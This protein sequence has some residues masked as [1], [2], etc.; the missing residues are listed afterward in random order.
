M[1][2]EQQWCNTCL[3]VP[4][5]AFGSFRRDSALLADT[6]STKGPS[7]VCHSSRDLNT[8]WRIAAGTSSA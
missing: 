5:V 2:V 8:G 6:N 3:T 1:G 7:V 4:T